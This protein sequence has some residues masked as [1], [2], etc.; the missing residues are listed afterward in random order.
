[1]GGKAWWKSKTVWFNL[2]ALVTAIAGGWGYTGELPADW[3]VLVPSIIAA[4]N[5]LL[6]L[7]TKEPLRWRTGS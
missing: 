6:R 2:L 1:M 3:A 4:V 5:L 7:V